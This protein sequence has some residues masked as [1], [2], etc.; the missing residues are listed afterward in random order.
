MALHCR[1]NA[2]NV[3]RSAPQKALDF[4]CFDLFKRLIMGDS[5]NSKDR[6]ALTESD[7]AARTFIAAGL[8]GKWLLDSASQHGYTL[9]IPTNNLC[10]TLQLEATSLVP[11]MLLACC[12]G[13]TSW[14][15]LYPIETVRS[16]ITAGTT[17]AGAGIAAVLRVGVPWVGDDGE[18]SC[19]LL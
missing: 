10:S 7:A 3:L 1:G 15:T 11:L 5:N 12:V 4:W 6:R 8:A 16:R 9:P 13:M 2:L 18:L 19:T 14:A 17:P